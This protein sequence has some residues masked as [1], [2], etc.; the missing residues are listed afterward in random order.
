V[1]LLTTVVVLTT[2]S[3][4]ATTVDWNIETADVGPDSIDAVSLALDSQEYPRIAYQYIDYE[5]QFV[6]YARWTGSDWEFDIIDQQL[7]Y[8]CIPR[9]ALDSQDRPHIVYY[10]WDFEEDAGR[11]KY[12]KWTGSDWEYSYIDQSTDVTGAFDIVMD[13]Q[14]HLHVAYSDFQLKDL[15]Y[16][17]WTGTNWE[18]AVVDSVGFVGYN[19]AIIVD[20]Q[21]RPHISH[22]RYIPDFDHE[23][24]YSHW[25]GTAWESETIEVDGAGVCSSITVDELD[26][27][28]ISY[29]VYYDEYG[30]ELRYAVWN[31][32]SW[33]IDVIDGGFGLW[34][35]ANVIRLD[36]DQ[37]PFVA[38]RECHEVDDL[39]FAYRAGGDWNVDVVESF[40]GIAWSISMVFDGD[41]RPHIAYPKGN[42]WEGDIELRYAR[43][44]FN[45]AVDLIS[46]NAVP[47]RGSSI[48]LTWECAEPGAGFNL[49][50]SVEATGMRK[51]SR[52]MINPELITG[53]SPYRYLD[54][55]VSD[56]VTY[57]YWLE[58]M[59]TSGA[60]E[61][62]GPVSCTAGTFVPGSYALYQSRPNPAR[63]TAVI[64]FD[65]PEDADVTLTIYDLSGRKITTLVNEKLPAG[66]YERPV[67]GLAPGVY[68]YRLAAGEFVGVG[69]MVVVD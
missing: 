47:G 33:D 68:V 10:W 12:A 29:Q 19:P 37:N 26:Y 30:D 36:D 31:G 1:R 63:G 3:A 6:K 28:R 8:G 46:F 45:T 11:L 64:A 51:K 24:K 59:D 38:Y 17:R 23:L 34:F 40:I 18:I 44:E 41:D 55:E 54:T 65:L 7:A 27:P 20:S 4:T 21:D 25:T 9:L 43:G 50:R 53:E 49:Y 69:K 57:S 48:E 62:F 5:G 15:K 60:S 67:S 14:D 2:V 13:E 52:E 42:T 58:A 32:S 56:G 66:A 61:T 22:C 39:R 16:A 35:E